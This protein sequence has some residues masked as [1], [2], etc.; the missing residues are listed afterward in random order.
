VAGTCIFDDDD[1]DD[2]P[3]PR[4]RNLRFFFGI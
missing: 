3:P 2:D 4:T 1:D